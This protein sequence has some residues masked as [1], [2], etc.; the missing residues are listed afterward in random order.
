M[1]RSPRMDRMKDRLTNRFNRL[2][3]NLVPDR[4]RSPSPGSTLDLQTS[5][6]PVGPD[7]ADRTSPGIP[8]IQS[9]NSPSSSNIYPSIVIT[10]AADKKTPERMADL[11]SAGLEDVK[12]TP[13]LVERATDI[14]PPLKSSVAG[15]LG[16]IYIMEVRDFQLNVVMVMVM[17]LTVTR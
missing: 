1:I 14:L 4:S 3:H 8:D 10:P 2:L 13:R 9:V 12:T 7:S 6:T 11:A 16:V 5:S 15:L 17:V